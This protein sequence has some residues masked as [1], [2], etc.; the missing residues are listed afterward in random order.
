MLASMKFSDLVEAVAAK[1][2]TPGG[3]TV[4]AAVGAL[5]AALGV[6]TAR[7][8]EAVEAETALDG[9]RKAFLP[10]AQEDADAYGQFNAALSLPKGTDE[11]KQRRREVLQNALVEASEV[12]LRGVMLAVRGLAALRDLAPRCNRHLTSDLVGA[13]VFLE[14]AAVGCGENVRVNVPRI[15]DVDRRQRL[16]AEC[17][18]LLAEASGLHASILREAAARCGR[19]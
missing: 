7:Y 6:M 9:V 19:K 3:G 15:A 11:E 14:A 8:S 10:L 17:T 12:P 18:R 13:A 2:P 1:T 4:A 5:G 16:E